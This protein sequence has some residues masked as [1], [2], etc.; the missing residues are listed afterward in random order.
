MGNA[1]LAERVLG[2]IFISFVISLE[3]WNQTVD[4]RLP[5]FAIEIEI[6]FVPK[7]PQEPLGKV[8]IQITST[9]IITSSALACPRFG[10][11]KLKFLTVWFTNLC[12]ETQGVRVRDSVSNTIH[13]TSPAV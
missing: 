7:S 10:K 9:T 6:F 11:L 1:Q 3:I 12:C 5:S 13:R 2:D 8:V 4:Y